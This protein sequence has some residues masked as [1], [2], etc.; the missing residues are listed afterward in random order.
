MIV[1]RLPYSFKNGL[2]NFWG[3]GS[4]DDGMD[5]PDGDGTNGNNTGG[6]SGGSGEDNVGDRGGSTAGHEGESGLAARGYQADDVGFFGRVSANI[7]GMLTGAMKSMAESPA[8]GVLGM[9]GVLSSPEKAAAIAGVALGKSVLGALSSKATPA[10]KAE[11]AKADAAIASMS[12]ADKASLSEMANGI[13]SGSGEG[14]PAEYIYNMATSDTEVA[15]NTA[16]PGSWE[17]YVNQFFGTEEGQKSALEMYQGQADYMKQ[18]VDQWKVNRGTELNDLESANTKS[19]GLLDDLID[20]SKTGTGLFSPVSFTL[21]GQQIDF[22]PRAARAQAEQE[23]NMAQQ[24]YLNANTLYGAQ[25]DAAD[26]TLTNSAA[27]APGTAGLGYLDAL[28]TM[29]KT[30][31]TVDYADRALD[32]TGSIASDKL[33]ANEP[34]WLDTLKGIG[35]GLETVEN[36][37]DMF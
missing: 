4:G 2:V 19:S 28:G 13:V 14:K 26:D 33:K 22:V 29:T 6:V 11:A 16:Q 10:D 35:S 8:K 32:Q 3:E 1:G 24:Q 5:G 17:Y 15:K 7:S 23:A 30:G 37:F 20:Q 34:G 31:E 36:I 27:V 12:P 21:A 9:L 18:Q 25:A